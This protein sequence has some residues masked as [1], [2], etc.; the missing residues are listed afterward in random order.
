MAVTATIL[1]DFGAD[2]AGD[3]A[4]HLSAELDDRPDG[5][6][7]GLTSFQPGDTAYFFVFAS[8]NVTHGDPIP[9]AGTVAPAT[10]G[11]VTRAETVTFANTNTATL[12]VPALA[13]T[14][15]AWMGTD[16]GAITLTDEMTVTAASSGVA[17]CQV[18][19]T[20]QPDAY[21]LASPSSLNGL[22]EFD[23]LVYVRGEVTG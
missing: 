16:L 20:T 23:I 9:S 1:V 19:Y 4:G 14:D 6:N 17:V 13:I 3:A 18:T 11:V 2:G 10:I 7:G 5:L 21:G 15:Y 22:T 8:S 12:P